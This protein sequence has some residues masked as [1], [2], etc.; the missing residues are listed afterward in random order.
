MKRTL[1]VEIWNKIGKKI[2]K[3]SKKLKDKKKEK[4]KTGKKCFW[5]ESV[6][7]L[8]ECEWRAA[9][10]GLKPLRLPRAAHGS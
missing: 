1:E 7:T 2:Q 10:P 4:T 3:N 6:W 5:R 9:A 8:A